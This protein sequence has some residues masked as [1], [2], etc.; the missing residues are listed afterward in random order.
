[1]RGRAEEARNGSA[2]RGGGLGVMAAVL[3]IMRRRSFVP[4]K[5][6]DGAAKR[7]LCG[8]VTLEGS[9]RAE[10]SRGEMRPRHSGEGFLLTER[11]SWDSPSEHML[12]IA[13]AWVS[14]PLLRAEVSVGCAATR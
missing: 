6:G 10:H 12:G 8:D 5:G 3:V 4:N 9:A 7:G 1:M 11:R 13:E 2:G 14:E